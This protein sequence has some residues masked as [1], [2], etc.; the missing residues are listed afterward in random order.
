[1]AALARWCFGHR[2]IV[3]VLWL[4]AGVGFFSLNRA[5]GSTSSDNFHLPHTDSQDAYN[6]LIADFPSQA[7]DMV[8]MVFHATS[9]TLTD[10]AHAATVTGLVDRISHLSHVRAVT[11]PLTSPG[12]KQLSVDRTIGLSAVTLEGQAH[13]VPKAAV[14]A[15]IATAQSADGPALRVELGGNAIQNVEPHSSGSTSELLGAIFA[16]AILWIAFGSILAALMPLLSAILAIGIGTSIIGLL[17]HV[18]TI[19]TFASQL[20]ILIG[21]GVGVDYAL[22]II[23]RH[24]SGLKAGHSPQE[25][26][27]AAVNTSGR[28]VF[29][30]GI[31]VCIALLG[32]FA[33]GISFLYGVAI[34]AAL[35]V[36]LTMLTSLTLLPAMLGFLGPKALSRRE[37]RHLEAEGPHE[38]AAV[39]GWARWAA[40]VEG[41]SVP[42]TAVGLVV[43]IGLALPVLSLRLGLSD[44]GNDPATTTTRQAYD[45]LA[46]GFGPGFSGPLQLVGELRSPGDAGAFTRLV[47]AV[48][49]QPGVAVTTAPRVS[50]NGKAGVA[51]VYPATAPQEAR[52]TALLHRIR[53]KLA[54][55]A[56]VGNTLVVHVG[57]A[58][59]STT[60]FAHLLSSKLPLF[61]GVVVVL[62]FVL[63]MLVFR[64][65]VVPLTAS[66]MNLLSVGAAFGVLNAVFGW[67]WAATLFGVDRTGPVD[68][69]VPVLLF[70]ILFGLSMDYEVFLVSRMHEA[71]V[72]GG[73][74][75][76]AVTMGQAATGR[77]ITAAA[78]I[79]IMV[80]GSFIFG[81]QRVIKE[82]GLGL[83]GAVLID[84]FVIRTVLVP[85]LMHLFGRANWWLP[86]PIERLLPH[87]SVD[88]AEIP[89]ATPKVPTPTPV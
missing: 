18:F 6:L 50:P 43:I 1:M 5:A 28:A 12:G 21:L 4:V 79:M 46:K 8:Q 86:G 62:A 65:L 33:L 53:G 20:A 29:F 66:V 2:R 52:T 58:T 34:S 10:A 44:E 87:V 11:N 71:W 37:R 31:I 7:G 51:I 49:A 68:V 67:G 80:F 22:F 61:I 69:F 14:K 38:E 76:Q 17:S 25:A 39:G 85:S 13:S 40:W 27:V 70:S 57:G 41:K 55:P 72:R 48:G 26:A 23:S 30:A 32:Q 89:E 64:S 82:F 15:I 3:L 77:V 81:G 35:T 75:R 59:A 36:L 74:N 78:V 42:L 45:L 88:P 9:G 54:P 73:D 47:A 16:L 24:R 60:D 56:E 63:L 19:A 83:G 84:A